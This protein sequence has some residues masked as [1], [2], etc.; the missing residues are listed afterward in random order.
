MTKE[1]DKLYD[2]GIQEQYY[3]GSHNAGDPDIIYLSF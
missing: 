2:T 1:R 3:H